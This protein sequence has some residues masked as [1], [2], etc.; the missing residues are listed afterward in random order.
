MYDL[1]HTFVLGKF[2]IG[3]LAAFAITVIVYIVN[4]VRERKAWTKY[5]KEHPL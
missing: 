1:F 5:K 3:A 4:T 2:L